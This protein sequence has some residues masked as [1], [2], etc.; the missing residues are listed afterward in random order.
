MNFV[1]VSIF[2]VF[3]GTKPFPTLDAYLLFLSKSAHDL[4]QLTDLH[5]C[6]KNREAALLLVH[7][8][9]SQLPT[10]Q[11]SRPVTA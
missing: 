1:D 11:L 2:F 9:L 8:L 5:A 10:I 4:V 7:V 6:S 3:N